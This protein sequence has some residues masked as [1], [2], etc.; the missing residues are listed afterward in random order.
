MPLVKYQDFRLIFLLD[1]VQWKRKNL[2]IQLNIPHSIKQSFQSSWFFFTP[3]AFRLIIEVRHSRKLMMI[4]CRFLQPI[5]RNTVFL[6]KLL[7]RWWVVFHLSSSFYVWNI[8]VYFADHTLWEMFIRWPVIFHYCNWR[9]RKRRRNENSMNLTSSIIL[10]SFLFLVPFALSRCLLFVHRMFLFVLAGS[11][12]C[13]LGS[14]SD[15]KKMRKIIT[16]TTEQMK[17]STRING[18]R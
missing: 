5:D 11:L 10:V 6:G 1:N 3:C 16:T 2:S 14:M 9:R 17:R 15:R 8:D 7:T 12:L 4:G 13:T 18:K